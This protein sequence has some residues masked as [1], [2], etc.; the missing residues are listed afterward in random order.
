MFPDI[1][2]LLQEHGVLLRCYAVLQQRCTAQAE[3]HQQETAQLQALV[4]RLRAQLIARDTALHWEREDRHQQL[5]VVAMRSA[6]QALQHC[7]LP[8]VEP[9]ADTATE[10]APIASDGN[11][12]LMQ[13]HSQRAAEL[14]IC[15][16][17]C[18]SHGSVWRDEELCKRTGTSCLLQTH[19]T[20]QQTPIAQATQTWSMHPNRITAKELE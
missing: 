2:Q 15:Q 19:P 9:P 16:T 20:A 18:I 5:A 14:V 11:A 6:A 12:A 4:T 3:A 1:D 13:L 10:P 7:L 17:G 8:S